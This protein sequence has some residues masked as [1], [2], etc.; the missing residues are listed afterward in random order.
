MLGIQ[1]DPARQWTNS[2]K[3]SE[4]IAFQTRPFVESSDFLRQKYIIEGWSTTKIAD[5]CNCS[6]ALVLNRLDKY[7]IQKRK[8]GYTTPIPYGKRMDKNGKIVPFAREIIIIERIIRMKE[9]GFSFNQIAYELNKSNIPT[10]RG[11]KWHHFFI[12]KIYLR[13]HKKK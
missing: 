1:V 10:K 12:R 7:G 9:Q 3:L 2:K 8:H 4:I 13:Y 5:Y 11:G 6:K